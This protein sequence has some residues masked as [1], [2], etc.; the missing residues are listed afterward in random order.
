MSKI[1]L[2][3]AFALAALPAAATEWALDDTHTEIGFSVRHMMVTDVKGAFDKYTGVI[4]IDEKDPTKS[5]V[6]V[7]IDVNSV[8]TKVAKRDAHLKGPDFFDAANHPKMTFKSTKIEKGAKPNT[9]KVT[10]DLTMRGVTKPITLDVEVSDAWTDPKEWGGNVHR[11]VKATGKINR[12]EFGL[13]WQTK[14]DKGG[15]VAG[16]EVTLN[17][18]A[19][20]VE[21]K[22]A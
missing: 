16:D 1:A 19:E 22:K 21:K 11:G 15:V 7:D 6:N 2:A 17:I 3:L 14:L 10:G 20:L 13:K 12:Q 9:Y 18:N 5:V 4:N 8:N